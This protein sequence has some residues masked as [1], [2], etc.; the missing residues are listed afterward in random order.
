MDGPY[1]RVAFRIRLH[2]DD[3]HILYQIKSFLGA[4]TVNSSGNRAYYV[5]QNPGQLLALLVP[6]LDKYSLRTTKLL[7]YIDFKA[8]LDLLTQ[9]ASSR[10]D[11]ANLTLVLNTIANMNQGRTQYDGSLLPTTPINP[12]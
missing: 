6:Y 12:L 9:S 4:G 2:I 8:M 5:L 10:M 1:L 11:G 7:D 3:I